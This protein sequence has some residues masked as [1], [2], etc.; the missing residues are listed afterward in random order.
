MTTELLV[1]P[2]AGAGREPHS[3]SGNQGGWR[4]YRAGQQP[5]WAD[6][7]ARDEVCAK[8]AGLPVLAPLDEI[9]R[10]R[11]E[12]AKVAAGSGLVLQAGDCAESFDE[13]TPAHA[14]GKAQAISSLAKLITE[15]TG[16][17]VVGIGRI[18]GQ[19]AKPRS[20]HAEN[21]GGRPLPVFRGHIVNGHEHEPEARR[22][23]PYRM[24]RA[25]DASRT[26]AEALADSETRVWT[27][28]EAL[29]LDYEAALV[30]FD[31]QTGGWYLGSTHLPWVGERTRHSEGA[32]IRLL[33]DVM[34]PVACKVSGTGDRNDLMRAI[35]HLDPDRDPGRLT[36]ISRF[37]ADAIER[38]LPDIARA[39][40]NAGHPVIWLCDPMHGNTVKTATGRKTRRLEDIQREIRG[41]VRALRK[42]GVEPGGLHL[43]SAVAPVTE[44]VGADVPDEDALRR[45]Y[46]TLC[47]PRL[48][49][50]QAAAAVETFVSEL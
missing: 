22:H 19:F 20:D 27:S 45:N 28:H 8:L 43:E 48:N 50:V 29:I 34:N 44:C 31:E 9:M 18:A 35:G 11:E 12:L 25:Y 49:P 36:L 30:R 13:C 38:D 2:D 37:G 6:P 41:F 3:H 14:L 4:Y 32:H 21:V 42:A 24:L 15:S 23:D 47:D 39:V 46:T 1:S 40:K 7:V 17:P 10:L 5:S 26:V 33:A 16:R